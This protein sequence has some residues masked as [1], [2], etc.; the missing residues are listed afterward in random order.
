[1]DHAVQRFSPRNP[2]SPFPQANIERLKWL[3]ENKLLHPTIESSVKLAIRK[4]F[5]FTEDILKAIKENP[6]AWEIY[7]NFSPA[8]QRNRIAY[9]NGSRKYPEYFSKRLAYF[10]KNTK[11]NKQ[12]GYGG[13]EKYF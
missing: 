1:M 11:E 6:V 7:N 9:I 10:I 12:Y 13:I 2:K 4:E 3:A 5:I 8:Y